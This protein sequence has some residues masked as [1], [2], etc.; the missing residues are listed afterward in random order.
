MKS[1]KEY[2]NEAS[3]PK[4]VKE[5]KTVYG[6]EYNKILKLVSKEA[7]N[8]GLKPTGGYSWSTI[9]DS[10]YG[11]ELNIKFVGAGVNHDAGTK[12]ISVKIS[13]QQASLI[14]NSKRKFEL[15]V[16]YCYDF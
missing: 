1:F 6:K 5:I 14:S 12:V 9:F 8:K 11:N 16:S 3:V 10:L 7:E 4:E 2:V 15:Y 13:S